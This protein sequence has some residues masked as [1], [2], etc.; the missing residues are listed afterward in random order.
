MSIQK[1]PVWING[2]ERLPEQNIFQEITIQISLNEKDQKAMPEKG[3]EMQCPNCGEMGAINIHS[4]KVDALIDGPL[5]EIESAVK[6]AG[7]II[8]VDR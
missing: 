6:A 3:D 7:Y 5:D 8:S 1:I 2:T 4:D